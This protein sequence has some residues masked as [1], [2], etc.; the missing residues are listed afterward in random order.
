MPT[1]GPVCPVFLGDAIAICP[2]SALHSSSTSCIW[3]VGTVSELSLSDTYPADIS[4]VFGLKVAQMGARDTVLRFTFPNHK[5]AVEH[6]GKLLVSVPSQLRYRYHVV[7]RIWKNI[8]LP[9]S[10]Q[11]TCAAPHIRPMRLLCLNL[12]DKVLALPSYNSMLNDRICRKRVGQRTLLSCSV[13]ATLEEWESF[14][15]HIQRTNASSVTHDPQYRPD[16]VPR[17]KE[18][19]NLKWTFASLISRLSYAQSWAHM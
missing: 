15:S 3:Q 14:A 8:P 6:E 10:V 11:L 9:S 19:W 12:S 18:S 4:V 17:F 5:G 13:E 16:D 7:S 1:I 2:L